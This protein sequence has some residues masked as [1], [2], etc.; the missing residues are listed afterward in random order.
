MLYMVHKTGYCPVCDDRTKFIY[1]PYK[2]IAKCTVCDESFYWEEPM[3]PFSSEEKDNYDEDLDVQRTGEVIAGIIRDE[4]LDDE[5]DV[6]GLFCDFMGKM[7]KRRRFSDDIHLMKPRVKVQ[8]LIDRIIKLGNYR[9][10]K[11]IDILMHSIE[12]SAFAEYSKK[13]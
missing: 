10:M 9:R 12:E 13:K 4:K 2:G 3:Y 7:M 6:G 5:D 8:Y 11:D 1:E